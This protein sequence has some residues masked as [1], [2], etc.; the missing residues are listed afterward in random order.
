MEAE[1]A[2]IMSSDQIGPTRA[3]LIAQRRLTLIAALT[4]IKDKEEQ[5]AEI[6]R[7]TILNE[8][9]LQI[10]RQ[11]EEDLLDEEAQAAAIAVDNANATAIEHLAEATADIEDVEEDQ[12]NRTAALNGQQ[13]IFA[14]ADIREKQKQAAAA[15][16]ENTDRDTPT[17]EESPEIIVDEEGD[18]DPDDPANNRLVARYSPD[19]EIITRAVCAVLLW[20][21][22]G[23]IHATL[24][25]AKSFLEYIGALHVNWRQYALPVDFTVDLTSIE[26]R[27]YSIAELF[28]YMAPMAAYRY[29]K[30]RI[31]GFAEHLNRTST[32][33]SNTTALVMTDDE[34]K[35]FLANYGREIR[36]LAK[37][38]DRERDQLYLLQTVM[39]LL[40]K[41]PTLRL[42]EEG[43]KANV[44]LSDLIYIGGE[45]NPEGLGPY[46]TG[47]KDIPTVFHGDQEVVNGITSQNIRSRKVN[48]LTLKGDIKRRLSSL[49]YAENTI[50]SR[51]VGHF[52]LD[53][54]FRADGT[55]DT[56]DPEVE[57]DD[58]RNKPGSYRIQEKLAA[59]HGDRWEWIARGRTNNPLVPLRFE[60]DLY[61]KST[62][63]YV[64]R[65]GDSQY[66]IREFDPASLICDQ[67]RT[68]QG[69]LDPRVICM[70]P[71]HIRIRQLADIRVNFNGNYV[72]P[73]RREIPWPKWRHEHRKRGHY[74]RYGGIR[75]GSA[76]SLPVTHYP[77][78]YDKTDYL[79]APGDTS[80]ASF[81]FG[82]LPRGKSAM[83]L[84][85]KASSPFHGAGYEYLPEAD[86]FIAGGPLS[87]IPGNRSFPG[88]DL[89]LKRCD[90]CGHVYGRIVHSV[91]CG[92]D[93]CTVCLGLTVLVR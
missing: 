33:L 59:E 70:A 15:S 44:P 16:G 46:L 34:I 19:G 80:P 20:G 51:M 74:V 37:Q 36:N 54:F 88:K 90:L 4:N 29:Y 43:N 82:R 47:L 62:T 25:R 9:R 72:I 61:R 39:D 3:A 26:T 24:I 6:D 73:N 55:P 87:T 67:A 79:F 53:M 57:V 77:E 2:A 48:Q 60:Q 50:I 42:D 41:W 35:R 5:R 45:A 85:Q 84:F 63:T 68:D 91:S 11:R 83:N 38:L 23:Q 69:R 17:V 13:F 58:R 40:T 8:K 49:F 86:R 71:E 12:A 32:C 28:A 76:R 65:R 66:T 89:S 78:A 64:V 93:I 30:D 22:P 52:H 14:S 81:N 7:L 27:A 10:L 1:V 75:P 56:D 31:M 21:P 92:H 18:E